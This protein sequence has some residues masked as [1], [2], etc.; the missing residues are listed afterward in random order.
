MAGITQ[1]SFYLSERE[2]HRFFPTVKRIPLIVVAYVSFVMIPPGRCASLSPLAINNNRGGTHV[3]I[4]HVA[5]DFTRSRCIKT[6][7]FLRPDRCTS[8]RLRFHLQQQVA[9][10]PDEFSPV[11]LFC[12]LQTQSKPG[13]A[14]LKG[15]T[16]G[17]I[18]P[19]N[20]ALVPKNTGFSL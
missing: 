14:S 4:R 5:E 16:C 3:F 12:R 2:N 20:T 13:A 8:H 19:K 18:V 1:T 17:F 15:H 11:L 9:I 10:S 6:S 7:V